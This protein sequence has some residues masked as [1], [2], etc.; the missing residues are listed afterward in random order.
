MFISI[1]HTNG[2]SYRMPITQAVLYTD[3]GW[4]CTLAYERDGL[5]IYTDANQPDFAG[6]V[7]ELRIKRED[8]PA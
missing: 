1:R 2:K 5:I 4:P 7:R 3:D 6:T 8:K